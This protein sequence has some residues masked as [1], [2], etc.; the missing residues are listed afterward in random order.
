VLGTVIVPVTPFG[1]GVTVGD[2]PDCRPFAPTGAP[3]TVPSDEVMPSEGIVVPTW[4]NAG[5]KYRMGPTV[6]TINNGRMKH[7]R[8]ERKNC[9]ASG[10]ITAGGSQWKRWARF[11]MAVDRG[12]IVSAVAPRTTFR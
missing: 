9:E 12:W 2:A 1:T 8:S 6:A 11:F 5:L 7:L 3:G 10:R 4:A